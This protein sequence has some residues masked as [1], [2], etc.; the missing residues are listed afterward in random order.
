[1]RHLHK[2]ELEL[3]T[4]T[5]IFPF[6]FVTDSCWGKAFFWILYSNFSSLSYLLLFS[7]IHFFIF[8]FCSILFHSRL[9]LYDSFH[10]SSLYFFFILF[11]LF[12]Y[13]IFMAFFHFQL[14][15]IFIFVTTPTTQPQNNLNT[16]V[17]LDMKITVQ[18]PPHHHPTPPQK[19]N[20]S[21][22]EP[23]IN[24]YWPQLNIMWPVTIVYFHL[25]LFSNFCLSFKLHSYFLF[26]NFVLNPFFKHYFHF[27]FLNFILISY[28]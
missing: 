2:Q 20:S 24:I 27:V 14:I 11:I 4:I 12:Y 10:F 25:F 23:R 5:S 21:L 6:I 17:G 9:V 8:I 26:L 28:F 1:M 19:L 18:S 3:F 7:L 22:Q 16:E 15:F 13:F